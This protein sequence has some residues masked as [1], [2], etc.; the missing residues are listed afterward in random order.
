MRIGVNA[1]FLL[2][3]KL[4]G[5]GWFSYETLKRITQNHPEHEFYFFFD[6]PYDA[7]FIFSNNIKPIVLLPPARHPFLYYIF[8][9]WSITQTLKKYKIDYFI[10]PDGFLS[11]STKVPSLAVIHDIAF[12]HRDNDVDKLTLNYY[13][14]FFPKFARKADRI[15]TVSEYT[16]ND[17]LNTYKINQDKI[18]VVYN[19]ANESYQPLNLDQ[20]NYT[21]HKFSGGFDYFIYVGSLNPRK[22][23]A[24]LLK[25]FDLF[26]ESDITNTKLLIVGKVMVNDNHFKKEFESM[27]F[28]S[29]VIFTGRLSND[30]LHLTLGSAKALVYIPFF[31]GFGIPVLESFYCNTPVIT[32]NT[33][34]LPEVAADAAILV[35]PNDIQLI[36]SAM[37]N[38][39]KPEIQDDLKSKMQL[40]KLDF[41]WNKTADLLWS[42]LQKMISQNKSN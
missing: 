21:K 9:E 15:A 10:S 34:S 41:T 24:N 36:S 1:R 29:D 4:E 38:I 19:G 5:I 32:S 28:K 3:D 27:K 12:E 18:D 7:S 11:L 33:T 35:D 22:N 31:E 8:F 25:S 16:K 26:K 30:D 20:I 40:R 6:R 42:S 14:Y 23:I 2:K 37:H 17:L 13:R 39:L